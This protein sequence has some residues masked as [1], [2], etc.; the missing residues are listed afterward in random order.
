MP[1]ERACKLVGALLLGV[2]ASATAPGTVPVGAQTPSPTASS[3]VPT[4]PVAGSLPETLEE[5]HDF[6]RFRDGASPLVVAHRGGAYPGLPENSLAVFEY[7]LEHLPAIV[8]TDFRLTLDGRV[9][10]MHDATLDRTTTGS[11][12]V[13]EHTLDEI[14]ALGLV[15]HL[16][17]VTEHR[18]HALEEVLAWAEDRTILAVDVKAPLTFERMVR[19]IVAAG[20]EA[21]VF[22][23]TYNLEDALTV[24]ALH[25][26]LM[27]S[28]SI[29]TPEELDR[30]V[31]SGL[32]LERIIAHT[33]SR[34]PEDAALYDLLAARGRYT[35]V[36]TLG[37]MDR[38]AAAGDPGLYRTLVRNGATILSTNRPVEVGEALAANR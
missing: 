21:R 35:M 14:R 28:T 7:A 15:D 36:G 38:E 23:Q 30:I 27:L 33:G 16:G 6:F 32:P 31:E 9:V 4:A 24:H 26:G 5:L 2:V 22:I 18:T 11:G 12:V 19:E 37:A 13:E 10:M 25:P 29:R 3:G 20:A 8:E 17:T 1:S 34:E